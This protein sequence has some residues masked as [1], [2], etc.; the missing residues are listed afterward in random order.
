MKNNIPY[1]LKYAASSLINYNR[2]DQNDDKVNFINLDIYFIINFSILSL[3]IF[4]YGITIL[5]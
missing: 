5:S 4:T 1:L 2:D 3:F